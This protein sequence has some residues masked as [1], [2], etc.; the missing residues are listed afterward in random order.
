ME[1]HYLLR[2][3]CESVSAN[4]AKS[5][6]LAARE[7]DLPELSPEDLRETFHDF[8]AALRELD[9]LGRA[10]FVLQLACSFEEA[11][12]PGEPT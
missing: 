6:A 10:A 1:L 4:A 9:E 3:F 2:G 5:A 11:V 12:Q 8:A 7:L